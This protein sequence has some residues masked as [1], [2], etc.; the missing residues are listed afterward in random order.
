MSLNRKVEVSRREREREDRTEGR[1]G[2][3]G[4]EIQRGIERESNWKK[5]INTQGRCVKERILYFTRY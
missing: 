1:G 4:E 3:I 2:D 5:Q